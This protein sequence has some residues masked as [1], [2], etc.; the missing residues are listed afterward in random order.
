[1]T[2]YRYRNDYDTPREVPDA[3]VASV[4]PGEEF[5]SPVELHNQLLTPVEPAG[6]VW[7][8]ETFRWEPPV[9]SGKKQPKEK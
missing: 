5:D 6:L 2:A 3:L 9:S 1:M 4:E 7:N 8:T